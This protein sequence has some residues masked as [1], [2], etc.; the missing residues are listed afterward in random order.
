MI[1]NQMS[2]NKLTDLG[3]VVLVISR[4]NM[5]PCVVL[6]VH[7][8]GI[9]R[10]QGACKTYRE[11]ENKVPAGAQQN[12][13]PWR[14]N[15]FMLYSSKQGLNVPLPFQNSIRYFHSVLF[16]HNCFSYHYASLLE[17]QSPHTKH[18]IK[19]VSNGDRAGRLIQFGPLSVFE[20]KKIRAAGCDSTHLSVI[21]FRLMITLYL[22]HLF[23]FM[24]VLCPHRAKNTVVFSLS[25]FRCLWEC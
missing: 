10:W 6:S 19:Q 21:M 3:Q 24:S 15:A 4:W 18:Q 14:W 7:L 2:K 12:S 13:T 5:L 17:E 20:Q 11:W 8:I 23:I 22:S 9:W 16:Q 25:L 1:F